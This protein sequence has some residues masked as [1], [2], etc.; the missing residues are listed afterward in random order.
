MVI[1]SGS[2]KTE[3]ASSNEIPCLRRLSRPSL[4]PIRTEASHECIIHKYLNTVP[5]LCLNCGDRMLNSRFRGRTIQVKLRYVLPLAQMALAVVFLR[6]SDLWMRAAMRVNHMPGPAPAFT[7]LM[8]M[9]PPVALVRGFLYWH[10]S[11]LWDRILSV[12]TIGA[13]WYWVALNIDSWR[14]RR[15]I[16]QFAWVPLR[17]GTD[18]MV[19][20]IGACLGFFCVASMMSSL[21]PLP[22]L[23][24]TYASLLIWSLGPMFI[25][26]R[27]LV[28]CVRR[29]SPQIG[30]RVSC[31]YISRRFSKLFP[32]VTSSANSRSLPTGMPIAMRVTFTPSGFIRR[33]R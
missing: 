16:L 13:L 31:N 17:M 21:L 22:W 5:R 32:M 24:P 26:G 1:E 25:F 27:D 14:E 7:L 23:V 18:L 33:E 28:Y 15:A 9:N 30:N 10:W 19:T 11:P 8:S 6:W 4:G 3:D 29:R 12:T 2:A 20:A